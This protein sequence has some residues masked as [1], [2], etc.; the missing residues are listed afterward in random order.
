M[1][2]N[3]DRPVLIVGATSDI[4]VALARQMAEAGHP[5]Y[6]AARDISQLEPIVADLK[7]RAC[8]PVEA[9]KMDVTDTGTMRETLFALAPSPK[10]IV[11]M[12]GQMGVQ[13]DQE[14]DPAL[15]QSVTDTNFTGPAALM[16]AG[17]ELFQSMDEPT[18]LV[19]VS[20]VA[21]DRGRARNYYYGAAKAAFTTMLSG[22][23]Q[24]LA[25]TQTTVISVK[26]GF[27][28]TRMTAGMDLPGPLVAS[29]VECARMIHRAIRKKREIVYPLKWR[30]V[31]YAVRSVPEPVFKKLSF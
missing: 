21:G 27:V 14:K 11:S 20:S 7:I 28:A 22:L 13:A 23:R 1:S 12:V 24:R 9:V 30:A 3:S 6:L 17:A 15:V 26:P 16:E 19:G 10:I 25:R 31:M 2:S 18:V 29:D 5:V 4:S 8:V